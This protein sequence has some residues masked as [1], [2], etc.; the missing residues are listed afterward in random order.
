VSGRERLYSFKKDELLTLELA[1]D[2]GK[3]VTEMA[4]KRV[5]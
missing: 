1:T 4:K 3:D 2:V 5:S